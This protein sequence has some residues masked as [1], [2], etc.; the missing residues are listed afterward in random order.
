MSIL[1]QILKVKAEEVAALMEEVHLDRL[2]DQVQ[3]E[4]APG[5]SA[6]LQLS[7]LAVIAE[8]K[9]S[10]PS[11]G[12]FPCQ[13]SPETVARSFGETSEDIGQHLLENA[14]IEGYRAGRLSHRQGCSDREQY[15]WVANAHSRR[16]GDS[17][18][19]RHGRRL[20]RGR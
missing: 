11:H 2:L 19:D 15:H 3:D 12:P 17:R 13:D 9:Y 10:S 5:F 7:D 4:P 6:G 1:D 16:C 18:F 8:I 20:L 14:A